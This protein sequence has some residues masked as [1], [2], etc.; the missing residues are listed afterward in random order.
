LEADV[1]RQIQYHRIGRPEEV[2][3]CAAAPAPVIGAPDDLLVRVEAFQ[4]N[5][6]DLLVMRG[7]YPRNDPRSLT[8]GNEAIGVVEAVGAAVANVA[9]GDRVI[10]LTVDNWSEKRLAKAHQVMRVS[11][12]IDR[13]QLV[14][15]KVNPAT[16][17]LML[18]LFID[19][20]PGGWF[21]QNAAN[22]AVGRA[23]IQIARRRG[24]RTINV[25]RRESLV[26]EM[27]ALG[28]DV[29]LVDGDDLP[30]RVVEATAGAA[31][32]LAADAVAG[33]ATNRLA[34]CLARQGS[35]VVY[36][37]TSGEAVVVNPALMVFQDL[38]LRGFWLTRHL[39]AAPYAELV[40]LYAELEQLIDRGF[41]VAAIDSV[42]K[43]EAI[44]DAVAR[45]CSSNTSGKVVV[46][47]E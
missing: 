15:L 4:I 23:A 19:L 24:I 34:S 35:L 1:I 13:L 36:G 46:T 14:G 42:F 17:A 29:V 21:L 8:L 10:L 41:L 18:R 3:L 9:P 33:A 44:K 39:A 11:P 26:A 27:N 43:V 22:S 12:E 5:P 45:A 30:R 28:G 47:F 31:I 25:V 20:Q 38:R 6:A 7:V 2:V 37:A 40:A 16:A 32:S